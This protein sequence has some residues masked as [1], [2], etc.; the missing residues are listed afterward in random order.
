MTGLITLQGM[1]RTQDRSD[2]V[3]SLAVLLA[4]ASWG[5]SGVF[6]KL[7]G[8]E[9]EISALALAFWRDLVTFLVLFAGVGLFR[10]DW[11]RVQRADLRWLAAL[12]GSLGI[13]HVFWNLG[14]FINGAAVATVQQAAMPAIVAVIAWLIWRESLTWTKIVSIILTFL[15]TV[16]V[17]GLD[18]L[19]QAD[20]SVSSF[21]VGLAIPVTY[22]AWNLFGKRAR[23][24]HNAF[25][26][27]TYGFGFGALVLLPLQA[28]TPQP[29]PVPLA[30]LTWFAGL[31]IIATLIP[32]LVHTYALGRLPASVASIL[33]MS[34]IA[35]VAAYAY[36]LIGER[37]TASQLLGAALVVG[38]VLLLFLYRLRERVRPT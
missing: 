2:L 10:R 23:E 17:S 31:I 8:V 15:G 11:L 19:G 7:I 22:A 5:L 4:A 18:V 25:T 1:F 32:F 26:T 6:V 37:L 3:S 30:A 13:F 38:G 20:L 16:L 21:L 9:V 24:N 27:I 33:L 29:W 36:I 14:V 35:F 12:G 34:E 28:F